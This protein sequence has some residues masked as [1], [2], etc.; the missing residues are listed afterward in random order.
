MDIRVGIDTIKDRS[1][2]SNFSVIMEAIKTLMSE[3]FT[4]QIIQELADE[5][6]QDLFK[7][8]TFKEFEKW[9]EKGCPV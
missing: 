2:I 1:S 7:I 5:P 9:I 6:D 8:S 3:G 4:I